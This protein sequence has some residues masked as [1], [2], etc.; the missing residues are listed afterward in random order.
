MKQVQT[1]ILKDVCVVIFENYITNHLIGYLPK[2]EYFGNNIFK[3]HQQYYEIPQL[4]ACYWSFN[5]IN[6]RCNLW[7]APIWSVYITSYHSEKT[8]AFTPSSSKEC[9][10]MQNNFHASW[11][12][13]AKTNARILTSYRF[14][15]IMYY[16][17][18]WL[19]L[20]E[21]GYNN[22]KWKT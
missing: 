12:K 1:N 3:F 18:L 14:S 6:W 20:I 22:S 17:A 8:T 16:S 5:L 13:N 9:I 15:G 10:H 19:M 11:W 2:N 21:E 4:L 7:I